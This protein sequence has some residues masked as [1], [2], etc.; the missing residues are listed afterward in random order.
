MLGVNRLQ[1]ILNILSEDKSSSVHSLAQK[2][3]ASE[4]TIR[5]DL[6][7]LEKEGYVRRV[8]GGVVLMENDQTE[9][10][11][12]GHST[13][14][15]GKEEIAQKAAE[16][17]HNGDVI[18]IDASST[19]GA[20]IRYLVRFKRLTVIT[21]SALIAGGL[22]K[23]DARVFVTGGYMPQNSQGFVGSYAEAM[24]RNY[25]AD[26]LFFSCGG[27]AMDGQVS[28]VSCDEMSIRRV[29]MQHARKRILLCDQHKFGLQHC[30]NLCA[31]DEVDM[32]I[33]D[34][35]FTGK[36]REKQLQ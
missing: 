13:K 29:M 9:M 21:N 8:F 32:L 17:I 31:L 6:N 5:R 34:A 19:A 14:D 36:G 16:L 35:P 22:Q 25:H 1:E 3:Y 26:L 27:L 11:F 15:S 23:L 28:D 30:F 18:M 24:V 20:L 10:P 12:F 2:L 7:H 4:A 33:S